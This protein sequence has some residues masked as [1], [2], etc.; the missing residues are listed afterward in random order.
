MPRLVSFPPII[1]QSLGIL[2][3]EADVRINSAQQAANLTL[4]FAISVNP[5]TAVPGAALSHSG[6]T[7]PGLVNGRREPCEGRHD[8]RW[9]EYGRPLAFRRALWVL[10]CGYSSDA[11]GGKCHVRGGSGWYRTDPRN[12][13]SRN[14]QRYRSTGRAEAAMPS[15]FYQPKNGGW[16]AVECR[17]PPAERI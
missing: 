5:M 17:R 4:F 2:G 12:R 3:P 14:R 7:M 8:G 13:V 10:G 11:T 15:L 9:I 16:P 1:D 6:R